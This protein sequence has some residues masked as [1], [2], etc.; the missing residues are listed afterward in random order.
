MYIEDLIIKVALDGMFT[1]SDYR[2]TGFAKTKD[3]EI[4]SNMSD[5]LQMGNALTE[6]QAMFALRILRNHKNTLS[7]SIPEITDSLDDPKWRH[8]FRSLSM[9]KQITIEAHTP[10]S[11]YSGTHGIF[12]RF[13]YT[14]DLVEGMRQRNQTVHDLHRGQ[15]DFQL[16]TWIFNLTEKN[17]AYLGDLLTPLEFHMDAE[18]SE[19]YSEICKIR[20]EIDQYVPM[21]SYENNKFVIKNSHRSVSQPDPDNLIAALFNAKHQGISTW[22]DRIQEMIDSHENKLSISMLTSSRKKTLWIDSETT[23]ISEFNELFE[24]GGRIMIVVPGGSELSLTRKWVN[25]AASQG[26]EYSNISVMFR[27]PN[28]K[29]EFNQY[30]K[31][32]GLNNPVSEDT[33]I[34]FVSTKITKPIIKSGV[35]FN[36]AI[37]LG[38]YN[39][40]HYSM[41]VMLENISNFVYY[42]MKAPVENKRWQPQEL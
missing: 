15:W 37:N 32:T 23:A 41:N 29:A 35:K 2:M 1:F 16:K 9:A 21:L 36:T 28:E 18:F 12:V 5:Q 30:I 38:Y 20:E 42:S 17:I 6:K 10:K 33:K 13:P 31:E 40:M 4:L 22:D 7:H 14:H 26:I 24:H 39:H 19:Y 34:V 27:L 3:Y 8:P 11:G 25:F